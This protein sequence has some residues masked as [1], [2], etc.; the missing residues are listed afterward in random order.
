MKVR[1]FLTLT[2][3]TIYTHLV[4]IN[5]FNFKM[6]PVRLLEIITQSVSKGDFPERFSIGKIMLRPKT[7]VKTKAESTITR[8]F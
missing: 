8:F 5:A 1:Y 6:Y 7:G 2:L 3:Y 4:T